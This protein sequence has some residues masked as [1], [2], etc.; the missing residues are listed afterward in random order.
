MQ[1]WEESSRNRAINLAFERAMQAAT[2]EE[3]KNR[4]NLFRHDIFATM[5][6]CYEIDK[7]KFIAEYGEDYLKDYSMANIREMGFR[8]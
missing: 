4:L 1:V 3:E 2:S 5:S 8:R 7:A 6:N